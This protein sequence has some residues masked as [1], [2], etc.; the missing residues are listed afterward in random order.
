M[1]K[2]KG[3]TL[4]EIIAVVIIIGIIALI[5]VPSVSSYIAN[6][7]KTA[8]AAHEKS[9][10]EAAKSLTIEVINGKDSFALPR[11]GDHSEV[12]LNELIDKEYL[13]SLK[14]PNTGELCNEAMSYVIIKN[15]GSSNYEY[16]SCLYCGTYITESGECS[17]PSVDDNEK[18]VCGIITGQ[19]SEWTNKSRTI[20]VACSDAGSGC[21]RNKFTKVFNT[22]TNKG[23]IQISDHSGK[24]EN[25]EVNVRVDKTEPT[26][27][28]I[29][30][31]D[32]NIESTGWS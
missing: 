27:E 28:L 18:P 20:T 16:K 25:C 5:A 2:N 19:S 15:V 17:A 9:M 4:I 10:E 29:A 22:T 31:G 8:Y 30:E 23:V 24:T 6:S 13:A 32:D 11:Q 1:K 7:R 14:D 3:F 12:F 26:C 21:T